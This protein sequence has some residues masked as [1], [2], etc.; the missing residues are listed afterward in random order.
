[1]TDTEHNVSYK[2]CEIL[3]LNGFLSIK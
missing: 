2:N 3:L 1:M